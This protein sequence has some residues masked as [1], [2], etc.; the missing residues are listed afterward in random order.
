MGWSNPLL[1]SLGPLSEVAISAPGPDWP[2]QQQWG[3]PCR[4]EWNCRL[5]LSLAVGAGQIRKCAISR[6]IHNSRRCDSF[7]LWLFW[8]PIQWHL[9]LGMKRIPFGQCEGSRKVRRGDSISEVMD[10]HLASSPCPP[11]RPSFWVILAW[12]LPPGRSR[13]GPDPKMCDLRATTLLDLTWIFK[14]R[15]RVW[16]TVARRCSRSGSNESEWVQ[17]YGMCIRML[18][19]AFP[20]FHCRPTK[21]LGIQAAGR[22]KS[23]IR[24]RLVNHCTG[25]YIFGSNNWVPQKCVNADTQL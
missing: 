13:G 10:P 19:Q 15:S 16:I 25:M 24:E 14:I 7:T 23:R 3:N 5:V 11:C 1:N 18:E 20:L 17:C 2:G 6:I 9:E 22:R 21:R 8:I 4:V 12:I